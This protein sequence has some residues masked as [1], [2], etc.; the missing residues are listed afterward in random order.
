MRQGITTLLLGA[1][2]LA[3]GLSAAE[4]NGQ[5]SVH[6][7]ELVAHIRKLAADDMRGRG[8][9][10]PE[11]DLAADYIAQQFKSYGLRPAFGNTSYFQ[12]FDITVRT[13]FAPESS[14]VLRRGDQ[15]E[16]LKLFSDFLPLGL[17]ETNQVSADLVFVGYGI[18]TENPPYDDFKDVDVK[19]KIVVVMTHAPR[20]KE[21]VEAGEDPL[22]L[23]STL[24]SK[25]LNARM[26]GAKGVIVVA[27]PSHAEDEREALPPFKEGGIA[28]DWGLPVVAVH[29]P[30]IKSLL[31]AAGKD[32]SAIHAA[33]DR[34]LKP[35]SFSLPQMSASIDLTASKTR[36][37]VRN[38][39][40]EVPGRI[41][42][43]IV[44]GAHYDH[45]GLG[46]K[47]SLAPRFI[48]QPHHG[49]DDNASGVA[50]LLELAQAFANQSPRRSL[51]FAA[52]AGEEIGLLGSAYLVKNPPVPLAE[53]AA[54]INM[55][56]VGRPKS[57]KIYVTGVGTSPAFDGLVQS[58]C[59]TTAME[60]V[61]SA[62]GYSASDQTSFVSHGVPV[63]FFFSGLHAD[64]HKPSD[65]WDKIDGPGS[66]KVVKMVYQII[67]G[68]S[69]L[70]ERPAF[71]RVAESA[72][73][74]GR[75]GGGGYGAYFGSIPDFGEE[76][77]GV[78]F[79]D[80][81]DG[82]PAAKAGLKAGDILIRFAGQEI[83]NL[84]DFS[85][86][87]KAHKPGQVVEVVVLRGEQQMT[88][89]VTLEKRQ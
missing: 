1:A 45:L 2:A 55:D 53:I 78:K 23:Q 39:A 83:R 77:R 9:G 5:Q 16:R 24:T 10:S 57:N 49:A 71:V 13:D 12:A 19:D 63:L 76:V 44:V 46:E 36:K 8:N 33:I 42:E 50:G 17:G 38:V 37:P 59:K 15:Q 60:A 61:T 82:S 18:A 58:A 6:S 21:K 67:D 87:L 62:S 51:L 29:L 20:E 11:L 85:Y 74:T 86:T 30:V 43:W 31:A 84:Y 80:V 89:N 47:N 68:I 64:Y 48:G 28:E 34:D 40:A 4:Q 35:Q 7:D 14:V 3:A 52:F 54:M 26:H 32:F 66:E 69:T 41:D 79:A 56:M 70:P 65:T 27:D 73:P 72:P 22:A 88:V 81:K 25:A 75:S